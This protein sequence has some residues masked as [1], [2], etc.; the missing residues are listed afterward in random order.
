MSNDTKKM[1]LPK[2]RFPEFQGVG[3]WEEKQL[4][5]ICQV[6]PTVANMPEIFVY[7]DLE[8]VESGVL[9]QKKIISK[10]DSPSRAQRL[11]QNGD[12]IFQM[13]RPY[14]RNNYFFCNTDNIPYVAS[15]GYAQLRAHESCEYLFQY[16]HHNDFVERVLAKCTGS[17]YPAINSSDLSRIS[18]IIPSP[19]EQQKI[20]ATLSSLDDL[21]TAQNAQLAALQA[22]KRGLMQALFP[23]EGETVPKLRFPEFQGV[24]EWEAERLGNLVEMKGRIGYRGYTV[25]D[26]VEEGQGAIS[27][28]P[29]NISSEGSLS[30]NKC[31]FISWEKYDESPEIALS[32]GFT[33]LVKTGY[34]F[35]KAALTKNLPEK[36]TIN[37]QL[38]VLKP[39][40]INSVFLYLLIR[41]SSVQKQ[42][43]ERISGGDIPSMSQD[44]I[45]K[46]D[47][48]VP[49]EAEQQ[50]IADCLSSLDNRIT[51]Q[52]QKI[53][54]LKLHKKGLMQHLFP[55][56]AE[57]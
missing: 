1:A 23:A 52:S 10:K 24:G 5:K 17:S 57:A 16:L 4:G 42:I 29:G 47:V 34:S 45:S 15:T 3:E 53:E 31:T 22:H 50:K 38:V 33:V 9:L 30:F 51:A 37:P 40:R 35:G 44:T 46:F 11:L 56:A 2:L 55:A 48:L 14:Q 19:A 41:N 43:N 49:S 18:V 28:S 25:A 39:T 32:E 36:A 8:S 27:L 54:A 7:V 12:S 20:A 21:L 26:I 6:N 13:V